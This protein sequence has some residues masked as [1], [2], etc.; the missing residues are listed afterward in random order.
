MSK[1]SMAS[2]SSFSC[3]PLSHDYERPDL[4]SIKALVLAIN[5]YFL[6]FLG[7]ADLWNSLKSQCI[8]KLNI[9]NQEFFEFSE[10]SVLSNLY[11]GI[12]NIEAAI[13]ANCT[14]EKTTRLM[15]SE[16]MLQAP[17]LLDEHGVTAGIQNH[18]LVCCSYFYL[19]AVRKLQNDEWQVALHFLQAIL[20]SPRL[21]RTQ[22]APELCGTLFPSSTV[23]EMGIMVR[24]NDNE[25]VTDFLNEANI[26]DAVRDITRRCKH[27][28]MYYQIMLYGATPQWNCISRSTSSYNGES[29]HFWQV[30][31]SSNSSNSIE[32][33]HFVQKYKDEK[34]HPLDPQEYTADDTADKTKTCM[35]IQELNDNNKSF[36]HLDQVPKLKIHTEKY[37]SIK[38]L[39][40]VLLESQSDTPTSVNSSYS[41]YLEEDD[42][43]VNIDESTS[44]IR[45]AG[46][47]DL[48]PA[49]CEQTPQASCLKLDQICTM[50]VFPH[51]S[52]QKVQEVDPV[53][54]SR[55]Y[56]GRCPSSISDFDLSILELRNRKS[57]SFLDCNVE[58][59]SAQRPQWRHKAQ[60]TDQEATT[61]LKN[62]RLMQRDDH[63]QNSMNEFCLHSGKDS[64]IELMTIFEK[65]ISRLCFSE[66][67]AK[68]EEEYAVEVTS[69]YKM[70][71]CKK[72]IKYTILKEIILDQLLTAISN[73][74]GENVLR[75]SISILSTIASINKSA[76]EDIKKKG[77]RLCD[78]ATAL[79]QNVHE[80][81]ILIYLIEPS[82]VEIKTLDILPELMEIVCTSNRYKGKPAS[83]LLTP[84]AASLMIIEILVTAFD[85]ATNNMHLAAI[86]SPRILSRILDVARE[87]NL[88]ECI[89]MA[90]ILIK[91][92]QFDGQC[93]KHLSQITPVAPFKHLLKSNVKRAKFTA[94]QFFHEILC[95]PRSSAISLLLRIRKEGIDEIMHLL[96]QCVQQ[97]QPDYQLLA[98]NLFLQLDALEHSS[99]KSMFMEEAMQIILKSVGSEENSTL[100]QLSTFILANI[101]GTY[102]WTGEPYTVALLV[103]KAGVTSVYHRNMIRNFDWSDESLQ[104][105]GIDSWCSKIAKGIISTGRPVFQ[106]LDTGIRSKIR[107]VSRNSLTAIAWI[108]CEISKYP[109]SLRNSACE[110]LLNGIEQFLHPGAAF[111]ERLLACLCIYNYTSGKG[112]QKLIHFSEGVRESLRRFSSVT[113]VAEELHR[114]ADFYL[115]NNSRISCV[116]TQ[117]LEAKHN[118]S[119]A[120][121]ALIYYMGLLFSGY[122][123]GSIKVWDIKQQSAT[124]VWDLK[125]HKKA[126]T[127]FSL[128]EPGESLLSG[129]SDKTIRVWQMVHRKLECIEVIAMKESIQKIE[130]YGQMIFIITQSHGMK[131]FDSSRIVREISKTKKVKCMTAIQG[132]LYIGCMDS[133]IQELAIANNREREIKQPIKSWRMQKKPINSIAVHKDWLYSASSI[134]EGSK[135]KEW[136]THYKPQMSIVIGKGRNIVAMEAVEDFIYLNCSSS[137]S[138][139]QIWL[140]GTQQ[141]VGRISAGSRITSLITANDIVLCGTEKG[142][143]KGWIPL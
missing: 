52:Q 115:P 117:I 17:A 113:W 136:R 25:S 92:M 68:C 100:Q 83:E 64:N 28:L 34:V 138:T 132:T 36:N 59:N 137:T 47:D 131:V 57:G 99:G 122:S 94:L 5:E 140:R 42:V 81:A 8:S 60:V 98:A 108:G 44:S 96:L 121:T 116:H 93:R 71:D 134:V 110:I 53:N 65:A 21:V 104:D 48:Q 24:K 38:C 67:L 101:G 41:Y 139:L 85:C 128:F 3:S 23:L 102:S 75:A 54:I 118:S 69:V 105:A 112:M 35:E 1:S 89:S 72:G 4:E 61:A 56:S 126:V 46:E 76:I 78:L 74:K 88:E 73:S 95:M 119:G 135:V 16:R 124:L 43:E 103:K 12:E 37:T 26:N 29:Q 106:A 15:N 27:W 50:M 45:T 125:E 66:G 20:V 114:V 123:D 70:L 2:S 80:A 142:L 77:L 91:C 33:G 111:E 120:V 141:N 30:T 143:I 107:K 86:N 55:L 97:L 39:Q 22:L 58:D 84:P 18:Y 6:E 10:H 129:S 82:P 130:T 51:A 133:S 49:V 87:N 31:N 19:S 63:S 13:Q 40:E 7:N 32:E 127:C 9:R 11:W 14:G 62:C 109:N 90:N 79:K